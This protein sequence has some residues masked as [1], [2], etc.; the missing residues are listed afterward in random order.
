MMSPVMQILMVSGINSPDG[1]PR[2]NGSFIVCALE[3]KLQ[4]VDSHM[5]CIATVLTVNLPNIQKFE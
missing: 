1:K 3:L 5:S 4:I 2:F